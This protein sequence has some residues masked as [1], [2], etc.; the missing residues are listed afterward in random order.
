M[1]CTPERAADAYCRGLSLRNAAKELDVPLSTYR[2]ALRR[3]RATGLCAPRDPIAAGDWSVSQRG[4]EVEIWSVGSAV[5]TVQDAIAKAEIDLERYEITHAQATSY[6]TTIK[7]K[8]KSGQERPERITNWRVHVRVRPRKVGISEALR[9]ILDDIRA[10]AFRL[11]APKLHVGH[12]QGAYLAEMS[13]YDAH[14]GKR[15]WTEE[16]GEDGYD[17]KLAAADYD[18]AVC[19]L[20][21]KVA[22]YPLE[23]IVFPVGHDFFNANN[24]TGTTAAG[25]PQSNVDDRMTKV[26]KVGVQAVARAV[27]TFRELAPVE[28]LWIPG[29][30]DPETSFYLVQVLAAMFGEDKHVSFDDA[31]LRRKARLYGATMLGYAHGD[32]PRNLRDYPLLMATTWPEYWAAS[33]FREM[34]VGHFHK[35]Q[36]TQHVSGDTFQGVRVVVVPS[37]S[38]TDRWHYEQ[39][40]VNN[41]RA[42]EVHLWHRDD[43]P[44]GFLPSIAVGRTVRKTSGDF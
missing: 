13:L 30:H 19:D 15:C 31:P 28:V 2:N 35:R 21:G 41:V 42:A 32:A 27:R 5:R 43:G 40:Y 29:N 9:T 33:R 1:Q 11:E 12:G 25:T 39:G 4:E 24:W 23:K 14:F 44:A 6:T 8:D 38:G 16:T 37:L 7:T 22:N 20:A 18:H 10:K 3:A 26:F 17:L 34:R 36:E